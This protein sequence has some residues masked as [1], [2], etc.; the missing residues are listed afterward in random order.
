M[1]ITWSDYPTLKA[2]LV[3]DPKGLGYASL[4]NTLTAQKLNQVGAS[5]EML[6]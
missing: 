2:E 1:D 3:N 5:N 4:D 6:S